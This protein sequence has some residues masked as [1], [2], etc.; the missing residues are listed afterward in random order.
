MLKMM[1]G[2]RRCLIL[3]LVL[4]FASTLTAQQPPEVPVAPVPAQIL[5]GKKAFI[6]NGES[7]G[8][9]GIPDLTYNEFY[10]AMKEW[11]RYEL[12]P[13]P[14]EADVVLEVRF[15]AAGRSETH[16]DVRLVILD[17]KTHVTLWSFFEEVH[18]A[19]RTATERKNFDEAVSTL[20]ADLKKLVAPVAS[21]VA[22][23]KK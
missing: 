7:T 6:S 4:V 18:P 15:T 20:V 13:T 10:A 12:V 16:E 5:E 3:A 23:R 8:H 21:P 22:A 11:G 1:K 14:S 2:H 17:P 19:T 9:T